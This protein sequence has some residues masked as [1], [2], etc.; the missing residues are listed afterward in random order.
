MSKA[1]TG[2]LANFFNG[3]VRGSP[4]AKIFF[5]D[6]FEFDLVAGESILCTNADF[7]IVYE[8]QT[9]V[10]YVPLVNGI[11]YKGAV[12]LEVDRQQI[13][14]SARATDTINGSPILEAIADGAFDGAGFTR[15]R[16]FYDKPPALGG[17]QQGGVVLFSGRVSTVDNVGRTS[18][19][20]T[21]ASGLVILDYDMPR[22]LYS[23]N[24][25]HTL[26]D[27]GC[28]V[29][30]ASFTVSGSVG[31]GSTSILINTSVAAAN[32]L[33][34]AVIFTSGLNAGLRA[35]VRS[36]VTGV[37]LSL[38]YPLQA[39]PS[40]GDAFDVSAGCDHT[41]GTCQGRFANLANFR[42]F[43]F[44]PPPQIAY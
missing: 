4:D 39:E 37:S 23:P 2:Q 22:N 20:L 5:A 26:Y 43:P 3:T 13:V 42:G 11:K 30:R 31:A 12:G 15:T 38:Q 40:V 36:F 1:F 17:N 19:Q 44:I 9:F 28:G 33:Q 8:G 7:A 41:R 14:V 10:P 18:A 24:C 6:L 21:V 16:V 25:I 27:A 29:D 34:G 32:Q 35:T